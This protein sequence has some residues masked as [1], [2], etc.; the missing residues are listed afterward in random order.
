MAIKDRMERRVGAAVMK[1]PTKAL[2]K[3]AGEP[4]VIDGRTLDVRLQ[5]AAKQAASNPPMSSLDLA[6]AR[7]A[8]SDGLR[9][10]N[11]QRAAG[12]S[13]RDRSIGTHGLRVR[14]YHPPAAD[15][16]GP[17]VL[18]F[19]Q[20]GFVVGDLDSCD[21]F[22]SRMAAELGAVVVSL[23][24]RLAPE[25][26]YPAQADD[27]DEAWTWV[28]ANA[29]AL[30]IDVRRLAVCGDSAGGQM[31]AAISQRLRDAG[32]DVRPAAQVLIYPFV[33]GTAKDGSMISCAD[34]FPLDTATMEWFE[35]QYLPDG[36]EP[37]DPL[38]SPAL[39]PSLAGLPAAIVVTAGFDPLRDQ[40]IAHALALRAA[41][42]DVIDR[43]ED[44]LTHSF[45]S[46]GGLVPEAAAAQGRIIDDLRSI[47]G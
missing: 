26:R 22:C 39:A 24:Y 15:E 35:S 14:I 5:L 38:V 11:G 32:A 1:L 30:G 44:T 17:G 27:A 45:L 8:A 6:T 19:H 41:G 36:M 12:V 21:T 16:L 7:A 42:V 18:F 23:D 46:F 31:S 9:Q 34:T 33:D 43:C 28:V 10:G 40:G 37:S 29:D 3:M 25:R 13:V 2:R 20:G 47:I 4:L